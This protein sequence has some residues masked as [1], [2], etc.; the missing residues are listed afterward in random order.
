MGRR[1]VLLATRA[2]VDWDVRTGIQIQLLDNFTWK[3]I[4]CT[5]LAYLG[6]RRPAQVAGE[7]SP[8]TIWEAKRDAGGQD[9]LLKSVGCAGVFRATEALVE[10]RYRRLVTGCYRVLQGVFNF[11]DK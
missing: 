6:G 7:D 2:F 1:S 9:R 10:R 8:K 11:G 4:W 5:R 3:I